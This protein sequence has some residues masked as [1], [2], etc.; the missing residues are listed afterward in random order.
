MLKIRLGQFEL[1]NQLIKSSYSYQVLAASRHLLPC[2]T[3]Y[4]P[5]M[6][7]ATT[8][9]HLL[10]LL[11]HAATYRYLLPHAATCC[12]FQSEL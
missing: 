4:C 12:H 7:L 8:C 5:L 2:A 3:F 11:P 6:P 10:P 9:S 1:I